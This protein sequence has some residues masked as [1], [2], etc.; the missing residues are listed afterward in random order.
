MQFS[1]TDWFIVCG[2]V[3]LVTII[4]SLFYRRGASASQY[5]LGGRTMRSL[6]VAISLVAADISAVSYVGCPAWSYAH[7]LE[8]FWAVPTALLVAPI[9]MYVFMP[10][11]SRFKFFTA[12]EYLERRFD[13]KTRVVGSA[14]FLLI[15]GSH[16]AVV[17]Y[18]PSLVLSLITGMH[19]STCV[20]IMGVFTTVYTTLGG[21]KAV[22]WT[23]VMQFSILMLGIVMIFWMSLARIPGGVFTVYQVA[24]EAGRLKFFNFSFDPHELTSFWAM[25]IGGGVLVLSVLATDQAYLQRYFTTRSLTESRQ[26]LLLD[27]LI[28]IPIGLL[29]YLMGTVLFV[30]YRLHSDRLSSLPMM[31][32]L[33]P[34]F[35]LHELNGVFSGL[36][37]ASIFGAS[38]AVMSASI[39]AL[40]TATTVDFYQRLFRPGRPESHYVLVGRL[41]TLC[42]GAAATFAALFVNRL[43]PIVNAFNII[44]SFLAGPILGI[45]LLGML[46]QKGKGTGAV[47]GGA[48]GFAAVSLVAWR[49]P[50]S[51][52]YYALI[53]TVVTY[54]T[55]YLLSLA[56]PRRDRAELYGLVWS[57]EAP[58]GTIAPSNP[59]SNAS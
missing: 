37:I 14:I 30:Y 15:R 49:S 31:D 56:G 10:F 50:I 2:Y 6:P 43:G 33:V 29:Q 21:M 4:G 57:L 55:G 52:F 35:V 39:N 19:L 17:I 40:T 23:D 22:I 9:V 20:L 28:L 45:F 38:M 32:A 25:T 48:L 5:F 1:I 7:N 51:F 3:L 54:I 16:A 24:S 11:Y 46:T 53:G 26:A 47:F 42:W 44:N 27:A 8:L 58:A 59:A 12:Y 18:A 36:V 41:G 13:L 34:F